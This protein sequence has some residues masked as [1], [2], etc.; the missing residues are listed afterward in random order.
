MH[1]TRIQMMKIQNVIF[2][3]YEKKSIHL[4]GAL[5]WGKECILDLSN[6]RDKQMEHKEQSVH[7]KNSNLTWVKWC[8]IGQRFLNQGTTNGL[9]AECIQNPVPMTGYKFGEVEA[10][11]VLLIAAVLVL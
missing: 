9:I 6:S 10:A 1:F 8:I 3:E 4:V 11:S 5:W 2:I 7:F